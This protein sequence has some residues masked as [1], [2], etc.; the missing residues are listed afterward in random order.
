[1]VRPVAE[2]YFSNGS[3][4]EVLCKLTQFSSQTTRNEL[5]SRE[6]G[7]EIYGTPEEDLQNKLQGLGTTNTLTTHIQILQ[8]MTLSRGPVG[9]DYVSVV[10]GK[11]I[12][13]CT[14]FP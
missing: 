14:F 12:F 3:D 6:G 1:M 11:F 7:K 5:N 9:E 2:K 4:K 10:I 8:L 13:Y